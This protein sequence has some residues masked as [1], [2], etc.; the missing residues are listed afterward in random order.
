MGGV[1]ATDLDG[2][3]GC[4]KAT[5]TEWPMDAFRFVV[6]VRDGDGEGRK[7]FF[8]VEEEENAFDRWEEDDPF[9]PLSVMDAI[10]PDAEEVTLPPP[11]TFDNLEDVPPPASREDDEVSLD[12]LLNWRTEGEDLLEDGVTPVDE[13]R[14]SR[15]SSTLGLCERVRVKERCDERRIRK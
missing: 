12:P 10:A 2:G 3:R 14:T 4:A 6:G 5:S 9:T 11:E 1:L 7:P 13:L 8:L 15:S